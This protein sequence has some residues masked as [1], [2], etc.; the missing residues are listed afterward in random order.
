MFSM[1][2]LTPYLPHSHTELSEENGLLT[3]GKTS[4]C[5]GIFVHQHK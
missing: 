1:V 4:Q 2:F 5:T 3:T